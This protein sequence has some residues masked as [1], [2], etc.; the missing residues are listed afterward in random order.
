MARFV[1]SFSAQSLSALETAVNAALAALTDPTIRGFSLCLLDQPRKI[2][3]E[4]RALLQYSDTGAALAT[5]FL[6]KTFSDQNLADVEVAIQTFMDAQAGY[7]Y[8]APRLLFVEPDNK[9]PINVAWL[10]YNT[11]GGA[12]ANYLLL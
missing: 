3:L 1:D 5:P 6:L 11:T 10:L 2:N 4:L 12:S 7:F 9:L 8:G